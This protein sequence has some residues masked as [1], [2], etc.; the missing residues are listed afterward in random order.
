MQNP[1]TNTNLF[2]SVYPYKKRFAI[3]RVMSQTVSEQLPDILWRLQEITASSQERVRHTTPC[4]MANCRPC[5]TIE[6][7]R[8][9]GRQILFS[10][11]HLYKRH[12]V[13]VCVLV[14][15]C[16]RVCICAWLHSGGS[17]R[18]LGYRS[19]TF[20]HHCTHNFCKEVKKIEGK[21]T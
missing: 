1:H 19:P 7:Y 14:C 4:K 2:N 16:L 5:T 11:Q 10:L 20:W 12:S 18:E 21:L 8:A 17:L 6:I 9:A 13:C 3:F 15:G